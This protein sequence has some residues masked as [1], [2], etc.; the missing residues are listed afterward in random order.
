MKSKCY[1][2]IPVLCFSVCVMAQDRKKELDSLINYAQSLPQDTL[3]AQVLGRIHE[4]MMFMD[5]ES[6]FD[7]AK[8]A[9]ELSKAIGYEKGIA[10]GYLQF[11]NYYYNQSKND[12]S[13]IYH[14]LA[15]KKFKEMNS[16][17][18]QIFALHSLATIER[19][20]GN[21]NSAIE[22]TGLIL[23]M[24][25]EENRKNTDLGKFDLRGSEYEVL[26]AIY[27]EKG[28]YKLALENTLQALRLFEEVK[29]EVRAA[30]ALKQ[31][32][33]IEY[34]L[35]N[36]AS[37]LDYAKR[38]I[39]IYRKND[40]K[41][42]LSYALNTA[43]LAAEKL[44]QV[45]TAAR[46][47]QES[48]VMAREMNVQSMIS[49]SLNDIAR[50]RSDEGK[51]VEARK[52][53]T[54]SLVIAKKL[55]IKLDL[56][57]ALQGMANL[58]VLQNNLSGALSNINEVISISNEIG[59]LPTERDA[60]RTRAEI[61]NKMNQPNLA[62]ADYKQ[63][64]ALSDTIYNTKK[65]QQIEELK[66]IYETEKKESEIALQ[67]EQ[68]NTLNEKVKVDRLT[69]GLYGG[70]T[71]A[72]LALSGLLF[73]GFRQQIKKNKIAR[74]KQNEIYKQEIAHKKKELTSQ[75]LHLVQKNTFIQELM[76]NLE[77]IKNS[78]EKFKMEFRRMVMLL[79]KENASDKDWEVF[80]TYFA[81]VHNDFDQKLK[82]LYADIS[83]K[84]IR[85]A[86]FLR[87]NL[88]TKEIAATL[89]VL[90]DSILKSK[91]RLK[92]KLQLSKEQNLTSFLN[93]I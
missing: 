60:L 76:E 77:N 18:G 43:G 17:K 3:K 31:I 73:F 68:I 58:N 91:Y 6:A 38:A 19:E 15:L 87:M 74:E 75:T 1:I 84:E 23:G 50:L 7:Y 36:Y 44:R 69:K 46:Y 83:E 85:L 80:K 35:E 62:Y 42:Y 67:K 14:Q 22:L 27:I 53:L 16:V 65:S 10:N 26:G 30:D 86:A 49:Q 54:E 2:L 55:D 90:P 72:G 4:R 78:P 70:G 82:T 20:K 88:T 59:A 52:L 45:D 37:S 21:Y 61:R 56:T 93:Q 5:N 40:D 92:K 48:M 64:H 25:T 28:N 11:G 57:E 41:I 24:Y 29:D 9:F 13:E 51:F 63:Y 39:V 66:T 34:Q 89:N 47:Y 71:I 81:D 32:S 33:D 79:K 8:Q 12:S